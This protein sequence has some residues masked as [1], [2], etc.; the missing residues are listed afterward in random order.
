LKPSLKT[1]CQLSIMVLS[2]AYASRFDKSVPCAAEMFCCQ[3]AR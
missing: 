1:D 2:S 3:L